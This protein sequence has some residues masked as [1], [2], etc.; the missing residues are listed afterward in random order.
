MGYCSPRWI[1]DYH[2]NKALFYRLEAEPFPGPQGLTEPVLLLWGGVEHGIL[3]L[4]PAFALD[5]PP[6][7]PTESGPYRLEGVTQD[8]RRLFSL[9]FGLTEVS[10][11]GGHFS[12]AVPVDPGD[13]SALFAVTLTGPEGVATM[14]RSNGADRAAL[15]RD[16]ATGRIRAILRDGTVPAAFTAGSDVTFSR[17]LPRGGS[18]G[19][20]E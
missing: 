5:A 7:L 13:A 1:S 11:G 20:R 14:D 8:G 16:V 4:E 10:E 17:G 12:F 3:Q 2:F 6:V 9:D 19:V 18:E 15:V